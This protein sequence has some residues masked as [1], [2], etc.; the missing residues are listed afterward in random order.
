[1]NF[2]IKILPE[3][4]AS[5]IRNS[6]KPY[7][8]PLFSEASGKDSHFFKVVRGCNFSSGNF[9][10]P[11]Q[12]ILGLE[13]RYAMWKIPRFKSVKQT[14]RKRILPFQALFDC[15]SKRFFESFSLSSAPFVVCLVSSQDR[16]RTGN[17]LVSERQKSQR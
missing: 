5:G 11:N 15:F 10:L 7:A 9:N 3:V 12:L 2:L 8:K 4:S 17:K 1:M 6:G 13:R 14:V 16:I